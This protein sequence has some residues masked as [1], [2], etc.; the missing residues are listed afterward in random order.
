[1]SLFLAMNRRAFLKIGG[2]AFLVGTGIGCSNTGS[3]KE[4]EFN[5]PINVHSNRNIGHLARKAFLAPINKT[6]TTNTVIVGGGIAGLAAAASLRNKEF[7]LFE[8]NAELGGTSSSVQINGQ[9]FSQ[10]AHYDLSYPNYYGEKGLNLLEQ[11]GV[12]Q[13]NSLANRWDFKDKDFLI[14]PEFEERCLNQN[15]WQKSVLPKSVLKQDFVNLL[16]PYLGNM[17]LPSTNI[18]AKYHYL[19]HITFQ[20]YLEKYLP[21]TPEFIRAIDYQ[22]LDDYGGTSDQVSALA[23]IHYYTCRPY[24]SK[25]NP[26][27]FSPP[28]GNNYFINKLANPVPAEA[29]ST[30]SLVTGLSKSKTGWQVEV[31]DTINK[32]KTMA[33]ATNV[34]YAGQKHVLKY[35]YGDAH[36]PFIQVSYSPWVVVNIELNEAISGKATIWQNDMITNNSQFLG[37]VNSKSQLPNSP[38]VLTAY[39]CFPGIY[40]YLVQEIE[41]NPKELVLETITH[42]NKYY[43]TDLNPLIKQAF[44]RI[45]GH[46]MPVPLT[47]YLTQKRQTTFNGLHLAGVDT[48]RLPLMFDALD[49]GIVAAEAF[50]Q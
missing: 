8:M 6:L 12:T 10:G 9:H 22:M 48:G 32:T 43:K 37:F 34:I 11:I 18:H 36:K 30:N 14:K 39:F 28:Q 33:N 44:V 16:K 24:Y 50:N 19:D 15:K 1:M 4:E 17:P 40:H 5:F 21:I 35:L 49:S 26:E 41:S 27:L 29:L 31:Y 45:L 2:A 47:G 46:A 38:Q 7:L 13:F 3:K 20:Q 23:G 42:L 25:P